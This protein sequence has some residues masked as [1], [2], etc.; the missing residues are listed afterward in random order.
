MTDAAEESGLFAAVDCGT[1]SVR[2][3]VARLRGGR[4]EEVDR[5]LHITR[6]GQGVDATGEFHPDALA[7]T[8][9]AFDD[10]AAELDGLGRAAVRVV[11]T[12]AARDARNSADFF[13]GARRAFGVDAEIIPGAQEAALSFEGALA[14]LPGV[15]S[16][17]LVMDVGG[18]STELAL[19]G[20]AGPA[21]GLPTDASSGVD[22]VA[23]AGSSQLPPGARPGLGRAVSLDIGSVRL[24]ERFLASDP[25]TASEIESA[26]RLADELLDGAG[27]D[28]EVA[29]WVGVGGTAT[30]LAAIALGLER[31]D[32]SR[33]H[34]AVLS[35]SDLGALAE[36][37]LS[38]PVAEVAAIPTMVPGRA[39]VI[40]A[41][42]LI[43]RAVG[44]RVGVP[45]TVSESDILDGIVRRLAG[46]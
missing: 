9:A 45:L 8:F 33:V 3:L 35:R 15:P 21:L 40:C 44:R 36:R 23:A 34:G 42:A 7:R 11:A 13:A 26:E 16:P 27:V 46:M 18:G 14:G 19:G 10:F 25:P 41:G 20:S 43:C 12:S 22:A 39:D 31:Y 37:L 28:F 4:L 2:L 6:L 29:T 17:V 24:R 30:A 32:R 1:N 5:R 38:M